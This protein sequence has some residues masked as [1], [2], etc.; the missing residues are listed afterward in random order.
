M[1]KML[2]TATIAFA[3]AALLSLAHDVLLR[4][5]YH[6]WQNPMNKWD[7]ISHLFVFYNF[8]FSW[9]FQ[10]NGPYWSLAPEWQPRHPRWLRQPEPLLP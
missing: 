5:E 2:S 7:L 1:I 6:P 3:G 9:R 4:S 8:N 10:I